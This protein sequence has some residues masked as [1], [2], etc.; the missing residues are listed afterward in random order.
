[1]F[2]QRHAIAIAKKLGCSFREGGAH[3]YADLYEQ[4]K[5]IARFGIRRASKEI[6][7][8]YIPREL[9]ITQKQTRE[10]HD[11]TFSKEE[12]LEA[13]REKH[14]LGEPESAAGEAPQT[15]DP[16]KGK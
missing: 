6:G 11:C 16:D 8:A 12:Y 10:L 7:H 2:T 15:E 5:L 13:L 14:L 4:G 9:H 1:L 3:T